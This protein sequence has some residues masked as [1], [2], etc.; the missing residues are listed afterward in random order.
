MKYKRYLF[1]CLTF[2]LHVGS[3]HAT[4][5]FDLLVDEPIPAV[6][7]KGPFKDLT[8]D[9]KVWCV[10]SMESDGL[11]L[12]ELKFSESIN[13]PTMFEINRSRRGFDY[14]RWGWVESDYFASGKYA[15]FSHYKQVY[16]RRNNPIARELVMS[17]AATGVAIWR[18]VFEDFVVRG[19]LRVINKDEIADCLLD[20]SGWG[21]Y[22]A[23]GDATKSK[24]LLADIAGVYKH[25][26]D[27]EFVNPSPVSREEDILEVVP[28]SDVAAYVKIRTWFTNGHRCKYQGVFE[29]KASE[30][31][32]SV[33]KPPGVG[34]D[35]CVL[36]M[37]VDDRK[38]R[39]FDVSP[40]DYTCQR[41]CGSRGLLTAT[42]FD[43][44]SKRRIR[45]LP[46]LKNSDEHLEAI[47][48]YKARF[49]R[50]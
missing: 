5:E 32:I 31:L 16:E 14:S 35:L 34:D 12:A 8:V 43:H 15:T 6:F 18:A 1:L 45:Y 33:S 27:I 19:T 36:K 30:E 17:L 9:M 50:D 48:D 4:S 10:K 42:D 7:Q 47:K 37:T 39:F 20:D 11:R 44:K 13:G 40:I 2:L 26:V 21:I 28:I 3:V 41:Y 46:R 49:K 24:R 38:I 25:Y 29:Y 22:Q 23:Q